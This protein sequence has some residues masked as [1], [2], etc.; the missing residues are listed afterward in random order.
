MHKSI[1]QRYHID[2]FPDIKEI[3]IDDIK[4]FEDDKYLI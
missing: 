2:I 3:Y 1:V 4:I